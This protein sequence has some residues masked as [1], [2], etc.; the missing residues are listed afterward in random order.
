MIKASDPA[1]RVA[2]EPAVLCTMVGTMHL[3]GSGLTASKGVQCP[4]RRRPPHKGAPVRQ[5]T[6]ARHQCITDA[7][8]PVGQ[9]AILAGIE[10]AALRHRIRGV[11]AALVAR[12]GG[13]TEQGAIVLS[14]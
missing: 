3:K 4:R 6:P 2:G 8:A 14:P 13:A 12:D 7:P 9:G 11:G 10:P 5:T 1:I